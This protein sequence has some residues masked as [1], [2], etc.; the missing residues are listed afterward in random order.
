MS[1]Q[2]NKGLGKGF[3][4]LLPQDFDQSMLLDKHDR[5]QKISID[6]I[7]PDP[8]QPRS[9]FDDK[10]IG[11]LAQSIKR[12]G[13]LQP[14]VVTQ[15]NDEYYIV[16]GERRWRAAK[17]AGLTSLPVLVRSL[18][19]LEKLEISLVENVQR[20][21]LNPLE[22]AISILRLHEQFNISYPEIADR[23]GK[24]HSTIANIVRLLQLPKFGRDALVD[25]RISEGHARALLALKNESLQK[26]L[27]KNTEQNNWSVRRAEQFVTE[28]KEST[29]GVDKKVSNEK[30][31]ASLKFNEKLSQ[32]L[33][34]KWGFKVTVSPKSSG[35]G[36]R[37][38]M[39][40]KSSQD[41][42]KFIEFLSKA[43]S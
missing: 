12:H 7:K 38:A 2:T 5:V 39:N 42:E 8:K 20:V 14:L 35:N 1:K 33:S 37:I 17:K 32:E 18:E 3:G 26:I 13:I 41:L 16:A 23:L 9:V 31:N 11:E 22:Q 19:E 28:A 43:K 29:K 21:D 25:G 27:L 40:F 4:S 34:T 30:I 15:Q 36:G 10:L 24:A 6:K